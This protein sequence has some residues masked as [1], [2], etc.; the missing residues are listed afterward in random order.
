[1]DLPPLLHALNDLAD[2]PLFVALLLGLRGHQRTGALCV[3][4]LGCLAVLDHD[5]GRYEE[6]LGHQLGLGHVHILTGCR[7]VD[8]V[9]VVL[10][11]PALLLKFDQNL[12]NVHNLC[13]SVDVVLDT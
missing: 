10:V 11:A 3:R 6:L 7:A 4:L 12:G 2:G 9:H 8:P 1:M 5:D 13:V